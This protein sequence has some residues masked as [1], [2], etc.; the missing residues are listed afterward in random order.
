M[1]SELESIINVKEW[2]GSQEDRSGAGGVQMGTDFG[3]L[4]FPGRGFCRARR[5]IAGNGI[6]R[7]TTRNYVKHTFKNPTVHSCP[8]SVREKNVSHSALPI[9]HEFCPDH[10]L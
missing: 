6:A 8:T 9:T 7:P 3:A 4:A 2:S 1:P 5:Y 10:R